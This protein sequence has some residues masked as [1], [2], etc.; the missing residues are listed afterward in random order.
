M[1]TGQSSEIKPI[2]ADRYNN[3]VQNRA[4]VSIEEA[5]K[6]LHKLS[7]IGLICKEKR[8]NNW[9]KMHGKPMRRKRNLKKGAVWN[10]CRK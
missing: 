6:A 5:T 10:D 7:A 1:Y 8:S 9:L 3:P 4:G 2:K